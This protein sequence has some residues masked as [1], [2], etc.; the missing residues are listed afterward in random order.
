MEAHVATVAEQRQHVREVMI[1]AVD[2]ADT[3]GHR[4][5]VASWGK[6]GVEL[7]TTCRVCGGR[8]CAGW[9]RE[10]EAVEVTDKLVNDCDRRMT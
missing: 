3:N 4:L 5:H 10:R 6:R 8:L 2:E 9:D 7:Y 1:L